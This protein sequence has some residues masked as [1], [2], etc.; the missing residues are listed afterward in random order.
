MVGRL[1]VAARLKAKRISVCRGRRLLHPVRMARQR[2]ARLPTGDELRTAATVLGLPADQLDVDAEPGSNR[3]VTNLLAV[4]DAWLAAY[5]SFSGQWV[6]ELDHETQFKVVASAEVKANSG[7]VPTS[8]MSAAIWRIRTAVITTLALHV[9]ADPTRGAGGVEREP[10]PTDPTP[11]ILAL[12]QAASMM[13]AQW[14][15]ACSDSREAVRHHDQL[16]GTT[17]LAFDVT[18]QQLAAAALMA[19]ER[20]E[21]ASANLGLVATPVAGDALFDETPDWIENVQ[22]PRWDVPPDAAPQN[23]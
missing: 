5:L 7:G 14:R 13:L 10:E 21:A 4:I 3:E 17:D 18:P 12:L 20:M 11:A 15:D 19:M 23:R 6:D 1:G 2:K 16:Y 22:F 9:A 8:L